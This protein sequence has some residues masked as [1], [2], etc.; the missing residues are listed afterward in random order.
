MLRIHL[1]AFIDFFDTILLLL[2]IWFLFS[3]I[4]LGF[5]LCAL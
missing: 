3:L 2:W 5:Y 1:K 4:E